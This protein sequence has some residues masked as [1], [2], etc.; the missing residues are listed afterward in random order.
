MGNA[1][2]FADSIQEGYAK[3][4]LFSKVLSQPLHFPKF[5]WEKDLLYFYQED[6]LPALCIPQM[7][8]RNRKLMEMVLTQAHKTLGH[9]GAERMLKYIQ[10]SYWWSTLSKDVEKYC[11]SC[12]TCQAVKLS[13]QLP[14]GLL[15]SLPVPSQPWESI[16]MDFIGPLPPG[17][18]GENF[19]WVIIDRFTSMVHL[20]PVET[21]TNTMDL[22]HLYV[23]EV[24]RLHGVAKSVV[25]DRDPRFTSKFW[26]E[27][28]H[29]LRTRLLMSTA[30]HP[31]TDGATEQAN[32][33]I[34]TILC[35]AVNPDQGDWAEK[36]PMVEFDM[37]SRDPDQWVIY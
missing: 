29:I 1:D 7:L 34:N 32:C 25:S 30:F 20:I 4:N 12:G 28:N 2:G 8:H 14:T 18:T 10:Q 22:A 13:T 11:Q 31:Q 9:A 5:R 23:Q 15:H 36:V 37:N 16:A 26:S 24:V 33:T 35:A 21:T 27:V 19:L 17:P 6:S 3:D